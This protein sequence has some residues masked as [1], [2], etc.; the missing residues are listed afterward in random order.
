MRQHAG[1]SRLLLAAVLF[2][3]SAFAQTRNDGFLATLGELRDA[4]FVDKE[5]IVERLSDS[6][7]PSVRPVLTALLEDR[8]SLCPTTRP[9]SCACRN[10][11]VI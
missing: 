10:A 9:T 7:H 2:A 11:V 1:L 5:T 4:S 3:P 8:L 6:G